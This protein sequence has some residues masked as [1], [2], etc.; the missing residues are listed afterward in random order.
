MKTVGDFQRRDFVP[1]FQSWGLKSYGHGIVKT[2]KHLFSSI[3]QKQWQRKRLQISIV[4]EQKTVRTQGKG[5]QPFQ[6]E[7]V[8]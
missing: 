6:S 3:Y 4:T 2:Q 1:G 7:D 5:V 8:N